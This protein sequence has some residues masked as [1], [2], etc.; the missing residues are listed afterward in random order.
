MQTLWEFS[1][2]WCLLPL[3]FLAFLAIGCAA[4]MGRHGGCRCTP[5]GG[6]QEG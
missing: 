6:R 1:W 3:F 5:G 4:L 2:W